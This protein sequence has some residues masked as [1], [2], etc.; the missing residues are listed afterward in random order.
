MYW[1]ET[2]VIYLK[3][4]Q[5]QGVASW[6]TRPNAIVFYDSAP[7]DCLDSVVNTITEKE[8]SKAPRPSP[9]NCSNEAWQVQS[10]EQLQRRLTSE[11]KVFHKQKSS[12]KTNHSNQSAFI[13]DLRKFDAYNSFSDESK[14]LIR[15]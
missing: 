15:N 10:D 5:D 4:A 13:K 7:A 14:Q 11:S 3:S 1:E 8:V 12:K 9:K 2:Y 6:Q